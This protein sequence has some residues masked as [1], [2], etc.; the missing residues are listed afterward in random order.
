[1]LY[2]VLSGF[3]L[4]ALA[5]WLRAY[6]PVFARERIGWLLALL[7]AALTLYFASFIPAVSAGEV[8]RQ[9]WAWLPGLDIQLTFVL[10]GLSLLFALL[11]SFIGTFILIYAGSYLHGHPYLGRFYAIMLS[12]MASML[13]LVLADNLVSLFVF[14]ELTS[15]TSYLLIGFNH[16]D[17]QAR[18][19]AL[20]G[21]LV[22]VGGG[23][24]LLAGLV[25]LALAGNSFEMS[26]LLLAEGLLDS[27][28]ITAIVVCILLGTFTK[29][30]QFPFHFWLP[31]A[32]AAPTPVSAYLHSATMVKAGIYLM[33]RLNPALGEHPL[34]TVLLCSAGA[35]TMLLGVYLAYSATGVK[36]VLAYSTVMALGTLTLLIG[37]GTELA[38]VA[39]AAFLLGHSLYKGALFMVAGALDHETGTKD[40]TRMGGLGRA[41]PITATAALVAGL[42]LAGLPPLFGFIGKELM[43]E[44]VLSAQWLA[45]P[46]LVVAVASAA[47][48]VAV[49]FSVAIKPFW[50]PV[51]DTPKK[52][53]EAPLGMWLGPV[54]LAATS[55]LF[56]VVPLLPETWLVTA[57]VTSVRGQPVEFYLSLWHG[58]NL[59]LILSGVSLLAGLVLYLLW[60]RSRALL[61]GLNGAVARVGPEAGYFRLMD[62]MTTFAAWQTRVLQNG[63]M[64][65]Y[66]IVLVMTTSLLA[67]YTLLTQYGLTLTL[68]GIEEVHFYEW[69]IALLMVMAAIYVIFTRSRLG[70][71]ATIGALGFSVALIFI[72]F[73]APDLGITQVL[74]E[75]LT[76]IL[77]IL[78]L[79]RLPGFAHYSSRF[80]IWRD[81]S[82]AV[83]FGV[84]MTLL[85]LGALDTR[86]F[87]SISSYFVEASYP[88]AQGRNIVNVILVDFR[89]LDTL[90]EIFVL[91]IAALGVYSMLR[92]RTGVS[93]DR[94]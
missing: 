44:A 49:A 37:I 81:G 1:M 39:F 89:A 33:A 38:M 41:M 2:A 80:E 17:S 50:G 87:D 43:L 27:P 70:A 94:D 30:A 35:I 90:G 42:S 20:Q 57:A 3:V 7:P 53:H 77:L 84:V 12:F 59:P 6:L 5:P 21:L 8:I 29:S 14:W 26:E 32:M 54:V 9:Q 28:W 64:G 48:G 91:A 11:I 61:A 52:P 82:V 74:I 85:I 19:S 69:A 75:T 58:V 92:L 18:K 15:I 65:I 46:L 23:L 72:L 36:K 86:Y 83:I 66:M 34:W 16:E 40:L 88:E 31:N 13:G 73:S 71:V 4:A 76:V 10:D 51:G 93:R 78:V 25:M 45:L 55:L 79:F 24:A 56:G 67:G 68:T 63:V 62:G 47:L 22:T 60:G